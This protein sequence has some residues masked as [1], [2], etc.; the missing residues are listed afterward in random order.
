MLSSPL[1]QLNQTEDERISELQK[2]FPIY[3]SALSFICRDNLLGMSFIFV[4]WYTELFI[5]NNVYYYRGAI[6]NA[7][8]PPYSVKSA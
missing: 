2:V 3:N 5:I 8:G 4:S 7:A 1:C 6:A